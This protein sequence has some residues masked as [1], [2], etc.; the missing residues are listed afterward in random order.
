MRERLI[1]ALDV[2]EPTQ[3]QTIVDELEGLVSFYK[4][5]FWLLFKPGTDTLIDRLVASGHRV[6]IDAKLYDI[7]ETVR[8]GVHALAQRGVHM[9]TVHGEPGIMRAA[10][11]GRGDAALKIFAISVLTSLDDDAAAGMGYALSVKDLIALRIKQAVDCGIDGM[12][13]SSHDNPAHLRTL[14]GNPKLLIATPGIRPRDTTTDDHARHA[15]PG[16]AIAR[17]ADYLVVGRPILNAP[18]GRRAMAKAIIAEMEQA[19][20]TAPARKPE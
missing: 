16:E 10:I 1:V 9:V 4:I 7:G 12:I 13:A 19:A 3:A 5:G 11:D 8:M 20:P 14:G 17:G 15:T 18:Q 2:P 6:F